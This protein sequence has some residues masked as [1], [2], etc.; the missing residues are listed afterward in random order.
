MRG[1]PI[2]YQF[3]IQFPIQHILRETTSHIHN[4]K[5]QEIITY[6]F[7]KMGRLLHT[8]TV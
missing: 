5:K 3:T 4:L 8:M 6:N 7:V 2:P 1:N